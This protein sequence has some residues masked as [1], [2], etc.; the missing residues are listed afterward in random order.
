MRRS[1]A[2]GCVVALVAA[3]CG[4]GAASAQNREGAWEVMPYVGQIRFGD[5]G[6]AEGLPNAGDVTVVDLDDDFSFGFRFGYHYT[7]SQ[8]IEFSFSSAGAEG[9]ATLFDASDPDPMTML[10]RAKP[11][12]IELDLLN[13]NVNYLYNFFLH[14]RDKFVVYVTGGI[15]LNNLSTFGRD[16]DPEIQKMLAELAGEENDFTYNYGGGLRIFGGK[17]AG[18]RFDVRQ[19]HYRTDATGTE[20]FLE[21]QL[22]LT[23][24][25]G[26][27]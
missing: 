15:G 5:A 10:P 13:V 3:S 1:I 16:I 8:M 11:T 12:G 20:D 2:K 7:K 17:K 9:T 19:V 14:H 25:L 6:A 23:L 24:I 21:F 4:L 27:P 18:V 22:G 26:G